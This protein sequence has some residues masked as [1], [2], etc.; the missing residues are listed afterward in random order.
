MP[1]IDDLMQKW[2]TNFKEIKIQE[3]MFTDPPPTPLMITFLPYYIF[4]I[5][6][7]PNIDDLMQEWSADFEEIKIQG[8]GCLKCS[9]T[10]PPFL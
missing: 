6:N 1:N 8:E 3:K 5:R 7:M 4:S 9:P 10:Q 2:P